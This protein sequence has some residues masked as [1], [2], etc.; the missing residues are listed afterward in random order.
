[1]FF[2]KRKKKIEKI[3][4]ILFSASFLAIIVLFFVILL[5][6]TAGYF[7]FFD[8]FDEP[9]ANIGNYH[10][11]STEEYTPHGL[12]INLT[13]FEVEVMDYYYR[14]AS[15]MQYPFLNHYTY[16][17]SLA[18][19]VENPTQVITLSYEIWDSSIAFL[20]DRKEK[21]LQ[22]KYGGEIADTELDYGA[23]KAYWIGNSL[24]LR[25]DGKLI[26]FYG[27]TPVNVLKSEN[28]A[29]YMRQHFS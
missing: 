14:K 13:D 1:M 15:G 21:S 27:E 2:V 25:Y 29:A 28:C 24:L 7:M 5:S 26:C 23:Q 8:Y 18:D 12:P 6:L 19:S 20:L 3:S 4:D 11:E 22:R 17:D 10:Y 9:R 16:V